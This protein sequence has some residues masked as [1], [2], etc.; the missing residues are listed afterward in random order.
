MNA[1]EAPPNHERLTPPAE[2][3]QRRH[4]CRNCPRAADCPTRE[5]DRQIL[6]CCPLAR[7]PR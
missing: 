2:L 4:A 1:T 6:T 3:V 7:W 5:A